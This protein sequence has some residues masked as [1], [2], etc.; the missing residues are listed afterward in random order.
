MGCHCNGVCVRVCVRACVHLTEISLDS[1]VVSILTLIPSQLAPL[2]LYCSLQTPNSITVIF[3]TTMYLSLRLPASNIQN[4]V[5]HAIVG[6]PKSC[7]I[8]PILRCLHWRIELLSLTYKVLRTTQPPYLHKLISV[9]PPRNTRSSFL[10]TLVRPRTSSSLCIT[11]RSF[12][13]ASAYLWSQLS[14]LS[15]SLIPVP[16]FDFP[17]H[18]QLPVNS[19]L[20]PSR[21]PSLFHFQL[22]AY[23]FH[24][25]FPP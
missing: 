2:P 4:S 24:K 18:A 14:V 21:T 13:Y 16:V 9:Q 8:T 15:V 11:D 1:F 10:V 17:A 7:R 23:L 20:S 6:A 5:A 12:R 25:S 22:S 3:S 19:P